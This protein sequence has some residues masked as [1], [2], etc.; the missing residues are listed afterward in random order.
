[1]Q[2]VGD[3]CF[4][5]LSMGLELYQ[6]RSVCGDAGQHF[7]LRQPGSGYFKN[8]C[9]CIYLETNGYHLPEFT[10][11]AYPP[12]VDKTMCAGSYT[13]HGVTRRSNRG[14]QR[15]HEIFWYGIV[16]SKGM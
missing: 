15:D 14:S 2:Q 8:R 11:G 16:Y 5:S 10:A 3:D 7:I 1:M 4:P 9:A 12:P 13:R 6:P